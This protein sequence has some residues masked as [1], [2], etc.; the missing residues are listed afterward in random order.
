[1]RICK[2]RRQETT[3]FLC[4]LSFLFTFVFSRVS[5]IWLEWFY[6]VES[7]MQSGPSSL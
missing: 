7:P 3:F 2:E 5:Y 6:D 1:M 4:D